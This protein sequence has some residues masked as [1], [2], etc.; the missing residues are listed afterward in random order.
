M[1]LR[2]PSLTSPKTSRRV[3]VPTLVG[4]DIEPGRVVIAEISG[5]GGARVKRAAVAPLDPHVV[6]DGE[7]VDPEA[8]AA[9]LRDIWAA[10]KGL[11]K[12]VRIGIANQRTVVRVLDLPPIA[13]GKELDAAVRF[14]AQEALPMPLDA[15]VIDY[16][17]VE[18]IETPDGPKKRVVLVAARRDMIDQ[19]LKASQAAGLRVDGLDLSAFGLSRALLH[20]G[21]PDRLLLSV[22]GITNLAVVRAG[23]VCTFTRV[24]GGGLEAM[25]ADLAERMAL[26]LEHARA[27]LR[28]V[29]LTQPLEQLQGDAEIIAA[30]RY[31]LAEGVRRLALETRQSLDFQRAQSPDAA[32]I[33]DLVLTGPALNIEGFSAMLEHEVGMPVVPRVI[34]VADDL[35]G[36]DPAEVTVAAGLAL[37]EV[38]A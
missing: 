31:V 20:P 3:K 23:G 12:K 15:A 17:P 8:L 22:G 11:S 35:K 13:D 18:E 7:V 38:K 30:T 14:S 29:G 1:Q 27:W 4:V 16:V 5:G 28:H 2:S 33:T 19:M 34:E 25:A 26:T 32:P 24:T 10:H 9:V 21:D 36:I 37:G 6:R